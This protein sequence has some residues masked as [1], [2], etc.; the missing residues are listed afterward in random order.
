MTLPLSFCDDWIIA[1]PV[2]AAGVLQARLHLSCQHFKP[3]LLGFL[4]GCFSQ[5][6]YYLFGRKLWETT[7]LFFCWAI[8]LTMRKSGKFPEALENNFPR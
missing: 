6:G 2:V 5:L 7:F 4:Y 3:A 1:W 8:K